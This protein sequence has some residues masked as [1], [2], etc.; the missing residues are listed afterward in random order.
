MR[1]AM[2]EGLMLKGEYDHVLE[3]MRALPV[4]AQKSIGCYDLDLAQM[5]IMWTAQ[6]LYRVYWYGKT[7]KDNTNFDMPIPIM[8]KVLSICLDITKSIQNIE[9]MLTT[10]LPFPYVHMV[11]MLVHFYVI[12]ACVQC[13]IFL[14]IESNPSFIRVACDTMVVILLNSFYQGLLGLAVV[15]TNPFGD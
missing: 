2:G 5:P 11:T 3:Q 6:V 13:G 15:L 9:M 4:G 1:V 14:G 10:P 8:I 12:A 7:N